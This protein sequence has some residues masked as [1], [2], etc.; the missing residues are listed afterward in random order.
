MRAWTFPQAAVVCQNK[1]APPA[2]A[3]HNQALPLPFKRPIR[4]KEGSPPIHR[5]VWDKKHWSPDRDER[6]V[7]AKT[8]GRLTGL[9]TLAIIDP[10]SEIEKGARPPRAQFSAPSRKTTVPGIVQKRHDQ[11][12]R[13][14]CWTRGRVQPRPGRACSPTSE[15]RINSRARQSGSGTSAFSSSAPP[16]NHKRMRTG[17][18][19]CRSCSG[20]HGGSWP[21]SGFQ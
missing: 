14:Q 3:G 17:G 13:T 1:T 5:W 10:D 2:N 9:S 21:Q 18:S 11:P 4:A 7:T 15:F 8:F 6:T 20:P 12:L 16:A 19:K